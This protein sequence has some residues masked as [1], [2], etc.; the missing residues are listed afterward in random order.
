MIDQ[1]FGC[2]RCYVCV[3]SNACDDDSI[4]SDNMYH[5]GIAQSIHVMDYTSLNFKHDFDS[6]LVDGDFGVTFLARA[7]PHPYRVSQL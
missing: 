4:V 6:I 5:F 3:V 7:S 2:F 1:F